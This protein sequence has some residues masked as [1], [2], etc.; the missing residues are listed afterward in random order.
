[1]T[2]NALSGKW[3][4]ENGVREQEF[5]FRSKDGRVV[6]A[7]YS[8]EKIELEKNTVSCR[9]SVDITERKKGEESLRQSVDQL[10]S[11]MKAAI[12]SL[13]SA[14]EMR[15]P[16]TSGHQEQVT[17]LAAAIAQEMGLSEEAVEA[18]QVAGIVHD[19]GKLSIP[20][21][22][23]SKPARLTEIE[24]SLVK[25]HPEVG[26]TILSKIDFP[27]PI[28]KIVRQ[29][30]ERIDGT[31]YPNRL[32]GKD[33]LIEAKILGV[34]DV[35]EAMSSHRPY[36]PSLGVNEALKEISEKSGTLYDPDVV[37]ACLK[38]FAEKKFKF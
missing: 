21:E 14:I 28:A 18:I 9:F 19:I 8:A 3:R 37:K 29:H 15:D 30:H 33:L 1:M 2:G 23:L 12:N 31:G 26:Y 24:Y 34:A 4:P 11:T 10:R 5:L 25:T 6:V 7:R 22:I 32:S 36:R 27:W 35:V 17:K 16:Y 38:L 13:S 20:A